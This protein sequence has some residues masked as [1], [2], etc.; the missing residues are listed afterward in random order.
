MFHAGTQATNEY[1]KL[2]GEGLPPVA[3][4]CGHWHKAY[5]GSEVMTS[6]ATR[7]DGIVQETISR[8]TLGSLADLGYLVNYREASDFHLRLIAPQ[9]VEEIEA[10]DFSDIPEI[11]YPMP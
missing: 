7:I 6:G 9:G 4:D 5:F 1:Q 10:I 11:I 2:G 8:V 3:N